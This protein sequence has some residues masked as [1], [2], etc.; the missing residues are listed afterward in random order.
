M[1][2]MVTG[3]RSAAVVK[4]LT[5]YEHFALSY[6]KKQTQVSSGLHSPVHFVV[7]MENT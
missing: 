4:T 1:K 3:K 5:K 6:T 7:A 2:A